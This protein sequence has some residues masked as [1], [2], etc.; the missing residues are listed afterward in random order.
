FVSA[1]NGEI[2]PR[3]EVQELVEAGL[4]VAG[5]DLLFQGEFLADGKQVTRTRR[6]NNPREAAAYTFGYNHSLFA[7]RVHDLLT[8]TR[9]LKNQ[10]AVKLG[11]AGLDGAGPWVAAAVAQSSGAIQFAAVDT[12]GFRFGKV[13]DLQHVDFLPGGAKYG[14]LPGMLAIAPPTKLWVAGETDESLSLA[15]R[16]FVA[17]GHPDGLL[18]WEGTGAEV[19]RAA[20]RWLIDQVGL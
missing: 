5:V 4:T 14:D 19:R 3:P 2:K 8:L 9:H 16:Q 6:V 17:A 7:Q 20:V 11:M 15:R 10:G 13:L 1:A 12:G 18:R